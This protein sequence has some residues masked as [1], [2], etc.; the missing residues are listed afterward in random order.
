MTETDQQFTLRKRNAAR[1]SLVSNSGL[2]LLKFSVGLFSGSVGVLAEVVNSAA[3]LVGSAVAFFSVR[4][5]DE[6]PDR[7]HAYG[8]GKIENLSGALTG[9]LVIGG[10]VY[11]V[12]EAVSHLL[13]NRAPTHLGW[14]MVTMVI[15]TVTNVIVSRNLL[16][17]GIETDSPALAADGYH[18]RTDVI[19]S[20]G[21]LAGLALVK[22]TGQYWWDSVAALLVAALIM[23]VGFMLVREALATL[24][25]EALPPGEEAALAAILLAY[26]GVLGYHKLRTRRS[27]SHRHIDVHVQIADTN[28]FVEAHRLS[29]ELEDKLRTALPNLHPIIHI[30]P[31]QD[32]EAHQREQHPPVI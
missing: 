24:S 6:P 32:E 4:V 12:A 21:V 10:G 18:L 15:S 30:E 22:W 20:A 14:A 8:H 16:R 25:D 26:P 28:S 17:V 31:Y 9:T 29:E 23:R 1:L 5:G 27:G 11:A 7:T 2:L 3:D 19:T 13:H